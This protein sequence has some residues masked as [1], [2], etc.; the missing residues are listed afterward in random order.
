MTP[1]L[2][3]RIQT[4]LLLLALVG[5]PWTII[6][7]P[8]LPKG[9][10]P[11][12]DVYAATILALFVVAFFGVGWELVYHLVQQY[13]W[14]KDWPILFLLLEGIPEGIL[15]FV[16]VDAIILFG[17]SPLTFLLHFTSTWVLV[18]L[19]AIGPLRIFLLRWRFNGG[20]VW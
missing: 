13:R 18:W 16:V 19:V 17:P 20:R 11:I 3:G 6:V 10:A 14:E 5:L 9:G 15:T 1:T 2:I 4:R 8:F 7:V 12:G